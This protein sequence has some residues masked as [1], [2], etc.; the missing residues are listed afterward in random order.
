MARRKRQRSSLGAAHRAGARRHPG[1]LFVRR[2][3]RLADPGQSRLE[4]ARARASPSIS[5]TT[6]S[7]PTS[8][9]RRRRRGST[10]GRCCRSVISPAPTRM[11]P[12][13]RSAPASGGS[14]S[15]PRAG[16]TSRLPTI[17][18]GLTGG[19]RVMHVEWV[20]DPGYAA[21]AIRLRPRGISPPLA[22]DSRRVRP[23]PGRPPGPHRP[24]RLR[25][26]RRLLRRPRQ[27]DARSSTCNN[28]A[29]DRLR[30]AGVK[31][32]L[33]PPFAQGLVWRYRTAGQS[34]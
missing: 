9:C 26:R 4:R 2:S 13:S 3:P 31:T 23:R 32:G 19:E 17:W 11:R 14:I 24:S 21:R 18:A 16:A 1:T 6:A 12:G 34:T 10:G 22:V 33:W 30:L 15:T 28:W 20:A 27:G 8:S 29:S 25:P 5:P 7:M